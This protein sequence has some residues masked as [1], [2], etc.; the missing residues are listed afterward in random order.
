MTNE[1]LGLISQKA[2][3]GKEAFDVLATSEHGCGNVLGFCVFGLPTKMMKIGGVLNKTASPE[4][5]SPADASR[6]KGNCLARYNSSVTYQTR[7]TA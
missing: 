4:R 3:T 5:W 7:G 6:R 2:R 1:I